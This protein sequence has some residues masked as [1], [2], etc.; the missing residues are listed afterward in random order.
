MCSKVFLCSNVIKTISIQRSHIFTGHG[1]KNIFVALRLTFLLHFNVNNLISNLTFSHESSKV[2][3]LSYK[4]Y[5]HRKMCALVYV[6]VLYMLFLFICIRINI[7][8]YAKKNIKFKI[9]EYLE[10]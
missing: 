5:L 7:I 9:A 1:I 2:E 3:I 4:M 8:F 6:S 10:C